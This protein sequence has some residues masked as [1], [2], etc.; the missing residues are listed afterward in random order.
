MQKKK[1]DT[2]ISKFYKYIQ[3]QQWSV[4]GRQKGATG[5]SER[6]VLKRYQRL[7]NGLISDCNVIIRNCISS[8]SNQVDNFPM[9]QHGTTSA[10]KMDI[11]S[12][13][14]CSRFQ[15]PGETEI[16]SCC[17]QC[18]YRAEKQYIY[19]YDQPNGIG[20]KNL[21]CQLWKAGQ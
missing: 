6:Y 17:R 15:S 9:T 21:P 19:M 14:I 4:D 10:Q 8:D 5:L 20:K 12:L 3:S 18:K 11:F 7:R 16:R 13:T 1:Q 2:R